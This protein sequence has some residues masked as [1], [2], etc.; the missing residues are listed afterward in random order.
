MPVELPLW[1]PSGGVEV[2]QNSAGLG[3]ENGNG[4]WRA[5]LQDCSGM[6]GGIRVKRDG[7]GPGRD[8]EINLSAGGRDDLAVTDDPR[9]GKG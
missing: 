1:L 7:L 6:R 4:L 9:G 8:A 3:I 5:H 2:L